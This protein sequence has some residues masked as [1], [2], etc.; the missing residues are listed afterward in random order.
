MPKSTLLSTG[1]Q[2][3]MGAVALFIV[4]VFKGELS[5]FSLGSVSSRSWWGLALSDYVWVPGRVCILWMVVA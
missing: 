1:M 2:M 4:S 5:G 3:L